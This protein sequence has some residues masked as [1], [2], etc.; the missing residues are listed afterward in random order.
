MTEEQIAALAGSLDARVYP[1]DERQIA[2]I[3][4]LIETLMRVGG[5]HLQTACSW[6]AEPD[7]DALEG[8]SPAAWVAAGRDLERLRRVCRQDAARLAQ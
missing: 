7:P 6:V 8:L 3:A 5:A 4:E 2:V 1:P